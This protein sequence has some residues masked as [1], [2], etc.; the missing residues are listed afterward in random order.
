[1][2]DSPINTSHAYEV[3]AKQNQLKVIYERCKNRRMN[4]SENLKNYKT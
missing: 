3:V 2:D 4:I 1:M